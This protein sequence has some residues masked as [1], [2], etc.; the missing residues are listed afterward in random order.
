MCNKR[1]CQKR[2]ATEDAVSACLFILSREILF[3]IVKNSKDIKSLKSLGNIFLYTAYADYTTF[4]L[5][6]LGWMKELLD[7]IS[8]F[9]SFSGLKPSL[10]KYGAVRIGLQKV[11]KVAVCGIKCIDWFNY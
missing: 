1:R 10:S 9:S 11:V 7:K 3:T 5:K 6:N 4:F 2:C 8:L